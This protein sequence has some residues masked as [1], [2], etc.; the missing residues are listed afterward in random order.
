MAN[1]EVLQK[2]CLT[3]PESAEVPHFEKTS[4]RVKSKIFAT[5]DTKNKRCSV[6]LNAV[7]QDIFCS[8]NKGIVYAVDNAWGKQGWTLIELGPL[9]NEMLEAIIKSAYCAVAPKNLAAI[10]SK[11]ML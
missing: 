8:S 5:Y 6:K 2:L 9:K 4:F 3:M 11:T 10:V 7:D 1:F